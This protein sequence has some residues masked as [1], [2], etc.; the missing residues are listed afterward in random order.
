MTKTIDFYFDFSSP[1]GYFASFKIDRLAEGFGRSPVW[2]PM[3]LGAAF[4]K[5]GAKPLVDIPIK[6][7][8]S[9]LD[10]ER[11]GKFMEVPWRL[12]DPF[13]I[14]AVAPGRAFYWLHDQDAD[15]AKQFAKAAFAAYFAEG[16]NI[17]KPDVVSDIAASVGADRAA[18]LD[19]L[20]DPAVKDRFTRETDAAV[21]R[22]V[23]GSPFFIIDGE[24]F[25]GS[26]RMWMIKKKLQE[27]GW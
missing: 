4:K 27:T 14:A 3:F 20:Q 23:F 10:W 7:D 1:Y 22:G 21:E 19:T 6:D 9:R 5:T 2:K 17:S 24:G 16:R 8:Y 15:T 26:D 11:M 18:V 13:P 25:W 12:P